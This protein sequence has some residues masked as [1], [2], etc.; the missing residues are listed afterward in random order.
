MSARAASCPLSPCAPP[1]AAGWAAIRAHCASPGA[2]TASRRSPRAH[3]DQIHFSVSTSADRCLVALSSHGPVGVDLELVSPL[4]E[5]ERIA[6]TRFARTEAE[7]IA[8]RPA[9]MRLR[10]FYECWTRKEAYLK[11]SGIGLAGG[12][13]TVTVSVAE[14]PPRIVSL[15]GEDAARWTLRDLELG[16]SFAGAVVVGD[17]PQTETSALAPAPMA[18]VPVAA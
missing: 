15:V 14:A 9:D 1:S 8:E 12:L 2:P 10:T 18:L 17:C 3:D 7:A 13:D 11:A 5:F 6:A 4:P 16:E